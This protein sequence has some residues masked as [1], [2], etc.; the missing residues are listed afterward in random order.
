MRHAY[1]PL[2]RVSPIAFAIC[3]R[4][5]H[6]AL[7]HH[8]PPAINDATCANVLFA[9]QVGGKRLEDPAGRPKVAECCARQHDRG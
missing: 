6:V 5:C 2:E 1:A 8:S 4:L 9:L 7:S 3:E